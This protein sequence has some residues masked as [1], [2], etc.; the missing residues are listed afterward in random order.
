MQSDQERSH[1]QLFASIT[2]AKVVS[3]ADLTAAANMLTDA[4]TSHKLNLT[5]DPSIR[6]K[7]EPHILKLEQVPPLPTGTKPQKDDDSSTRASSS[8]P[9]VPSTSA[10]AAQKGP[11][12]QVREFLAFTSSFQQLYFTPTCR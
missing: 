5:F 6:D 11:L 10:K 7:T 1:G 3:N 2:E 9:E 12:V 4:I 8:T